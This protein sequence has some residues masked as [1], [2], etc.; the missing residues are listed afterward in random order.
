MFC[1]FAVFRCMTVAEKSKVKRIWWNCK[2]FR[3]F[4]CWNKSKQEMARPSLAGF[5]LSVAISTFM[6]INIYVYCQ[7]FV[8]VGWASRRSS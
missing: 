6:V 7:Y 1:K 3:L 8:T 2:H 4:W 5:H